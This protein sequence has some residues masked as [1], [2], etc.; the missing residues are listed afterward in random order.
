MVADMVRRG[1]LTEEQA[2]C[3]PMRNY[4]TRA[5]G[6]DETVEADI[7]RTPRQA[8]DRWLICS[9]G[10]Y[11]LVTKADLAVMVQKENLEEA[12]NALLDAALAN[13][14]RDNIS[15]VLMEDVC[16]PKAE[17]DPSAESEGEESNESDGE[18]AP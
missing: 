6:T 14:G 8:G 3:H 12:A 2:A 15:L 7:T 5:V 18:V 9:D 4:I 1:V 10:L 13:G 16:G 11:G 17:A